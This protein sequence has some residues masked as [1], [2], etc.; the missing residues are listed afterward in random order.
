MLSAA[1]YDGL[2]ADIPNKDRRVV[3]G[4]IASPGDMI[5]NPTDF[6][7]KNALGELLSF[8]R[9][10][11]DAIELFSFSKQTQNFNYKI[12]LKTKHHPSVIFW[13]AGGQN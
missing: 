10:C 2:E 13:S 3:F 4:T 1:I 5:E 6:E 9:K 8:Y 7:K 11:F 12:D